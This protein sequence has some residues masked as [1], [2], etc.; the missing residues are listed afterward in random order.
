MIS[1]AIVKSQSCSCWGA[2]SE[3]RVN[4]RV[5]SKH[6]ELITN[7]CTVNIETNE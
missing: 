6:I 4:K 7:E 2:M 3:Q 1:R 5:N